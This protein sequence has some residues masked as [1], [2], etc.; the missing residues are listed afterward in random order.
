V[1][2][3]ALDATAV[4][5]PELRPNWTRLSVATSVRQRTVMLSL[6]ALCR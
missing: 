2:E 4:R 1:V 3:V 5:L 6:L